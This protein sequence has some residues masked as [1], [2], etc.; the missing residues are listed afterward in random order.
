MPNKMQDAGFSVVV[1]VV[2]LGEE[3]FQRQRDVEGFSYGK[4]IWFISECTTEKESWV[5]VDDKK[6][7]DAL[8][9]RYQAE[10]Y[11]APAPMTDEEREEAMCE[12]AA[13]RDYENT[14]YAQ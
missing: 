6:A 8:E 7:S 5:W 1:N 12:D 3:T 11:P 14:F 13:S 10:F 4:P 9:A 2:Y